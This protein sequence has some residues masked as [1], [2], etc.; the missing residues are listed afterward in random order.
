MPRF[1][2]AVHYPLPVTDHLASSLLCLPLHPGLG[3]DDV[4]RVCALVAG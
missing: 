3:D 2:D 4:D 1:A